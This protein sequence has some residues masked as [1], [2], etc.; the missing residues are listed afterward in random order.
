MKEGMGCCVRSCLN[1]LCV[2]VS[3]SCPMMSSMCCGRKRSESGC[4]S[5]KKRWQEGV[6]L[7]IFMV[8]FAKCAVVVRS[9]FLMFYKNSNY[10][11]T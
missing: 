4:I 10:E 1:R 7:Y 8:I 11:S 3:C 2:W 9:V 5:E 6:K